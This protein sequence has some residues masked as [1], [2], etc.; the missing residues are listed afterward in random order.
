MAQLIIFKFAA[1]N[2][3]GRFISTRDSD[4]YAH[5]VDGI[6]NASL[7]DKEK[8]GENLSSWINS[9]PNMFG[10]FKVVPVTIT[11]DLGLGVVKSSELITDLTSYRNAIKLFFEWFLPLKEKY[12]IES[13]HEIVTKLNVDEMNEYKNRCSRLRAA[14][15]YLGISSA[16]IEVIEAECTVV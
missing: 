16:I 9:Y 13:N 12:N 4:G 2:P 3:E 11:L 6:E 1:I 10:D 14:E 5:T 8:V 15:K 7:C